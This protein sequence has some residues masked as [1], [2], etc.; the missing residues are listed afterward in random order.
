MLLDLFVSK[1]AVP[2]TGFWFSSIGGWLWG[3][4]SLIVLLS[5]VPVGHQGL[6]LSISLKTLNIKCIYHFALTNS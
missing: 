4:K 1:N 2:K 5:E 3:R 6:L